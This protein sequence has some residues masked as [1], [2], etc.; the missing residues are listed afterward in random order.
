VNPPRQNLL[1]SFVAAFSGLGALWQG[2]NARLQCLASLMV[3][4]CGAALGISGG[5]W[6]LVLLCCGAVLAAE[7]FNTALEKLADALH[8][9][10]HPLVGQA[11]DVAAAGVL[12]LALASATIGAIVFLPKFILLFHAH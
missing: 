11:K 5:E 3:V 7:C 6:C 4:G 10:R 9:E 8:P 1:A 12:L 2:R